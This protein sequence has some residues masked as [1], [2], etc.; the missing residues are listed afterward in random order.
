M[1]CWGGPLQACAGHKG[2][3]EA[4]VHAMKKI[5]DE[6]DAEA[7]LLV[8]AS[9]AF[10]SMNRQTALQNIQV[11]CPEIATYLVNTYCEPP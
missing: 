8:G 7:V 6:T 11:T 5:F 1:K 3:V 10:N 4:A 2:G 9:N